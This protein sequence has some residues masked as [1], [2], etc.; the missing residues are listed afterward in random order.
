MNF[1]IIIFVIIILISI[2]L[3]PPFF[4]PVPTFGGIQLW[5]DI[6]INPDGSR[7]Q[8]NLCL[9]HYRLLDKNNISLT[10][11]SKSQC[12]KQLYKHTVNTKNNKSDKELVI[13][14]H[15]LGRTHHSFNKLRKQ[16]NK[17]GYNAIAISYA[18]TKGSIS[19]HADRLEEILNNLKGISKVSFV[20]HSLGG[21]ILRDTLSRKS[22]WKEK[23]KYGRVVQLAPPNNGSS[24]AKI[25]ENFKPAIFILGDT[26][27]ELADEESIK[28]IPDLPCEYLIIAG[29]N[30]Y[31][32]FIKT[33]NDFIITLD[34]A[35]MKNA[36]SF[37]TVNS[38]HTFIMND[39]EA[40]KAI[41][42]FLKKG[43]K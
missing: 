5:S 2:L 43:Q 41:I 24:F 17:Y 14:I 10:W 3:I 34:E 33:N 8:Q 4:M 22:P 27:S 42:N 12:Y 1:K 38:S 26:L 30:C 18:S 32:A 35:R 28:R 25:I 40:I 39:P 11:G 36:K 15:G 21:I 16:L 37:I 9:R 29:D 31:N 6:Y 23:I 7:I 20:T 19:E 13:L